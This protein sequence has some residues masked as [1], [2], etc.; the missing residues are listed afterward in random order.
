MP[1]KKRLDVRTT[2]SWRPSN[3]P[4]PEA[5]IAALALALGGDLLSERRLPLAS[6]RGKVAGLVLASVG[7]SMAVWA[8]ATAADIDVS[9]PS[10]LISSGPYAISRNP[11]YL[12]WHGVY[13]GALLLTG[14]RSLLRLLP[15]VLFA[16][17]LVIGREEVHLA[18]AFGSDYEQYRARVRRYL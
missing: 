10:L 6:R 11:M 12:G 14:F 13:L 1:Q 2:G 9:A 17:N 7:A 5:H 8:V 18:R 16:T 15:A 4:V 3:I